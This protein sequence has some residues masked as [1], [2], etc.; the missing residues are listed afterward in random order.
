MD[1]PP[2]GGVRRNLER[3]A[4]INV[5]LVAEES[6]GVQVLR[7]LERSSHRIVAVLTQPPTRGG[8]ATVASVARTLDVP[9]LPSA[10]VRDPELAG[11]IAHHHVDVLLNVHSLFLVNPEVVG[12]PRIGSFNLHP[13]PL[14]EY[15]GLN[16]PSWAVYHGERSHAVTV[17]WMDPEI[18]TGP[19]VYKAPFD[20]SED[21]TGLSV[22]AKC[23]RH[24]LPLVERLLEVATADPAAIPRLPQDISR[25]QYFRRGEIPDGGRIVWSRSARRLV[26]L[27]RACDYFPFPSPWREPL[28]RLGERELAVLKASCTRKPSDARP[29]TVRQA[30]G[31][32][33]AVATGDEWILVH[34]VRLNGR[35]VPSAEVLDPG[36]RLADGA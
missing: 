25:C 27:V 2:P 35:P 11:F 5:L 30:E 22:S 7:G 4:L 32:A 34:R 33:V 17:H 12:A 9:V 23:V 1:G 24:G 15:A 18:D 19:I 31:D 26:D 6:A 29:G 10:A 21:D 3:D 14:P 36:D 8:G 28:A 13:G 20:M 16:A